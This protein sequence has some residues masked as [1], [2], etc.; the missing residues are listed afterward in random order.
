[1][2]KAGR[3]VTRNAKYFYRKEKIIS[4]LRFNFISLARL[5]FPMCVGLPFSNFRP[6][7][8]HSF[9][10]LSE[11]NSFNFIFSKTNPVKSIALRRPNPLQLPGQI[12]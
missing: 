9:P 5:L 6:F 4:V 8:N 7:P 3:A 11:S 10:S 2:Q 12:L 1:M